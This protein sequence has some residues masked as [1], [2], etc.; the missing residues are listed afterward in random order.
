MKKLCGYD[1]NGWR[2]IAVRNWILRPGEET[3]F[4]RTEVD[5]GPLPTVVYTGDG[6]AT[7]IGGP[8]A[9]LAPHGRGDGWGEVGRGDRRLPV[10]DCLSGQIGEG[11]PLLSAL[12]GLADG[13]DCGILAIDDTPQPD[14]GLQE[15]LLAAASA[16]R[17]RTRLLVWRPVLAALY[18][19]D[20]GIIRNELTVG[21]VSQN[22]TGFATQILRIRRADGKAGDYLAPE[23]RQVGQEVVSELGYSGL[24]RASRDMIGTCIE[25][26]G[27]VNQSRAVG[28]LA[29]GLQVRPELLRLKNADWQELDPPRKLSLPTNDLARESFSVL[30][31]CDLVLFES[32]CD[33]EVREHAATLVKFVCSKPITILPSTAIA[34]GGLVGAGRLCQGDHVYFDFLPRIST[35]VQSGHDVQDYPIISGSETLP[36]GRLYRSPKPARLALQRGQD[37]ISI[38]LRKDPSEPPRKAEVVLG[39]PIGEQSEVDLWVEQAPAAGRAK[40]VL[41]SRALSRQ[42]SVDWETAEV[43]DESWDEIIAGLARPVPT[44]PTRLI[45]PCGMLPWEGKNGSENP[46]DLLAEADRSVWADW[47]KL[48]DRLSARIDKL[49]CISSDGDLPSGLPESAVAQLDRLT[50]RAMIE[51]RSQASKGNPLSGDDTAPLKFLTWQFK[52]SPDA[53]ANILKDIASDSELTLRLFP[54][55]SQQVLLF[56][57]LGRIANK[58]AMEEAAL[59]TVLRRRIDEWSWRKETACVAFLLSRSNTAPLAL[60]RKDV[61]RLAKRVIIEF[62]EEHGSDYTRFNYAPFLLVGLLRWRLLEPNALV[63]GEDAVADRLMAAVDWA[64]PDIARASRRKRNLEKYLKILEDCRA[65]LQGK[66]SNPNLLLDIYNQ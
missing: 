50:A 18:A 21:V 47:P 12:R 52:R 41:E 8:Q 15:R 4:E 13:T 35:I 10:R 61:E 53:L 16:A 39:A 22:K 60:T 25:R 9:A 51:F 6:Q 55:Y 23:R 1:V 19:I 42:F 31:D 24:I 56:Q 45:L 11:E 40:V 46:L 32:L 27:D 66:G 26:G 5:G 2:D 29:F 3:V 43:L 7:W 36:A 20:R 49:H 28:N 59:R 54:K 44:I 57:G 17:I 14:E 34:D 65:E 48:A 64:L 33:G 58:P 37:R 30:N 62:K 63:A 38:Y